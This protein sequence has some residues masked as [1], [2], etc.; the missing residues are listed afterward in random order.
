MIMM[1]KMVTVVMMVMV[2]ITMPKFVPACF[3]LATIVPVPKTVKI[4][5]LNDW[6]PVAL[7]YI[8]S[9]CFKKLV[10]DFICSSLPATL[11]PLQFTYRQNRSTDDAIAL[12]LHTA[13]SHLDK[14]NTYVSP[15]SPPLSP[16]DSTS[17]FGIWV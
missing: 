16:Q 4:T 6:R 9:K 12:K 8:I 7:T 17:S 1:I 3:K 10:R 2:L 11:D 5:T 13:L 15:V 14:N